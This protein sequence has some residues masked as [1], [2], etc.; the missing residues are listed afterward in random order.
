[1]LFALVANGHNDVLAVAAG[2]SALLALRR[3]SSL[4]GLLAGLLL[5]LATAV[6]AQYAL[7]GAGL[8]LGRAAH[9][10]ALAATVLTAAV[11]LVPSYL[12]AGRAA[13]SATFGLTNVAP[14]GPWLDA[15]QALGWHTNTARSISWR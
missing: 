11:V 1:M 6:K 4:R 7:F 9:P 12:L 2:T 14:T 3:V 10:T 5:G 13:I 15:A 8:A